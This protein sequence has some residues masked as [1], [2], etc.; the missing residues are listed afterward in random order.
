M[1]LAGLNANTMS[2]SGICYVI[3]LEVKTPFTAMCRWIQSLFRCQHCDLLSNVVSCLEYVKY[4]LQ[5]S[6]WKCGTSVMLL[7]SIHTLEWFHSSTTQ[8]SDTVTDQNNRT[9]NSLGLWLVPL[10]PSRHL[11][12]TTTKLCVVMLIFSR[13]FKLASL[14]QTRRGITRRM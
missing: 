6:K 10:E 13:L 8:H 4:G 9:R 11:R 3:R 1:M 12:T 5:I 14:W 2:K 7:T